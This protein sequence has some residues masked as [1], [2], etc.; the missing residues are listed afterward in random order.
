[1]A[2]KDK[3]K[4]YTKEQL[5]S[6][7]VKLEKSSYGLVW[8]DKPEDIAD[9]CEKELPVLTE[10]KSK[11]I[12]YSK[13]EPTH[14]IIEGDNYHS[15]YTLNFTHK[16]NIDVI[17]IDPPYNT[18]NNTWRYNNNFVDK[19]DRFKHSK[20][21][22]FMHKRIKLAKRLLSDEGI[23]V[24]AIDEYEIASLKLML[25]KIFGEANRIGLVT[26]V[27]NP[28]GRNLSKFFSS[29]SEFMLVYAKKISMAKFNDV[30]IDED[31]IASFDLSDNEGKYRLEPYIRIRTTWL[32]TNKPKNYYPIYV[33]KDLKDITLKHNDNYFK[34]LP[35]TSDGKDYSW[36]N[37][38]STFNRLNKNG[39]FC[40]IKENNNIKIFHKYREKQVFKNVW[41]NK[42]YHSEFNGTNLLKKIL[43]ENCFDYPKSIFLME[44][45]FKIISKRNSI[46][47]DFFAGSGTTGHAVLKLNDEDNGKRQFII[48]TNNENNICEDVTYP[49]IKKVIDGYNETKGIP[50]NVKYYR[51]DFVPNILTDNDKRTLV[52]Q[53]TELLCIAENTFEVVRECNKFDFSIF[54][55]S[56]Q[57]TAIIYD[58]DYIINCC[59][60]INK[61]N[62]KA[63][64][65]IYVFS[66]DHTYEDDDF[67][68][69]KVNFKVKPIPEAIINVYRKL[70][71]LRNK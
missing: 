39:Y 58:E 24:C 15:L 68:T 9:I 28:K 67:K 1:M 56:K 43:G 21:L 50:A 42:K 20:W 62:P 5:I 69:L 64:L 40:A 60:E 32:R 31:K 22:S 29:N 3:Y 25:D 41:T 8:E 18:G 45:I 47:L 7:I 2:K 57:H 65:V 36:K 16:K 38:S 49:R 52:L 61:I 37:I 33:S 63:K 35:K 26:V 12:K 53:S 48:C 51:T 4:S 17:Y 70:T 66:Y 46:I 19:E 44:D 6:K 10:I 27:H 59:D 34:I 30:A 11:E 54:K 14:L 23:F 13:K 71:K 55:N